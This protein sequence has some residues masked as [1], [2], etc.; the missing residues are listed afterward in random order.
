MSREVGSE[1]DYPLNKTLEL[2]RLRRELI[3]CRII[4]SIFAVAIYH[5]IKNFSNLQ[6]RKIS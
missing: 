3:V 2:R 6:L 1:I 4:S 5:N